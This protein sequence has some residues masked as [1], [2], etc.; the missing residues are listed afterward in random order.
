VTPAH[1]QQL[2]I[3]S[4]QGL[5]VNTDKIPLDSV[6]FIIGSA[7]PNWLLPSSFPIE[8]YPAPHSVPHQ[9]YP[10]SDE[11]RT[12]LA[13]MKIAPM[14][15]VP[16]H[17]NIPFHQHFMAMSD[18]GYLC[19]ISNWMSSHKEACEEDE[20]LCW[21]DTCLP[22]PPGCT[23]EEAVCVTEELVPCCTP[24][25]TENCEDMDGSCHWIC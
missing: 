13:R 2:Q 9:T 15:S 16:H 12:V 8:L 24:T 22:L 11:S 3:I 23:A 20:A 25:V 14:H 21:M 7:L 5:V 17:N 4:K 1:R 18:P 19:P 10:S 6:I